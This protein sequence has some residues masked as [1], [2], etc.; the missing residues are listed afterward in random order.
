MSG[1]QMEAA[2]RSAL[3]AKLEPH[4]QLI[5]F[6]L[7]FHRNAGSGRCDPTLRTLERESGLS[8]HTLIN[9]I[10]SLEASGCL[11]AHRSEHKRVA[12]HYSFPASGAP[13]APLDFPSGAIPTDSVVQFEQVSGAPAAPQQGINKETLTSKPPALAGSRG[14]SKDRSTKFLFD[15]QFVPKEPTDWHRV[16]AAIEESYRQAN[17]GCNCPWGPQAFAALKKLMV[18]TPAW[19]ADDWIECVKHRFESDVNKSEPPTDFVKHLARF[20]KEPLDRFG[21]PKSLKDRGNSSGPREDPITRALRELDA[22]ARG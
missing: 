1:R 17:D 21:K 18:G 22:K 4:P 3:A 15:P 2:A 5:L 12:T 20:R 13:A 7:A 10:R 16:I 8:R 9:G 11:V 6:W 19:T 14:R